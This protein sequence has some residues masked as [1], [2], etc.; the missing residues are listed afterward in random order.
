M[1]PFHQACLFVFAIVCSASVAL[2]HGSANCSSYTDISIETQRAAEGILLR[3]PE[4]ATNDALMEKM[5]SIIQHYERLGNTRNQAISRAENDM[6]RNGLLLS[7][8]ER[9]RRAA[10]NGKEQERAVSGVIESRIDGDFNG[11]EGE[12]IVRLSNGQIWEQDQYYYEYRYAYMP[13]V[14]VFISD[15]RWKMLVDGTSRAVPVA[16]LK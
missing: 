6:I 14:I 8:K 15:G 3:H 9:Q 5:L 13:K 11:W 2:L 10:M 4:L 1:I 16:R 7:E 12:T